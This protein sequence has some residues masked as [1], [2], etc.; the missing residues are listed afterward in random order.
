MVY[1]QKRIVALWQNW[2]VKKWL[3]DWEEVKKIVEIWVNIF[4]IDKR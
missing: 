2:Y 4:T 3:I 1:Q